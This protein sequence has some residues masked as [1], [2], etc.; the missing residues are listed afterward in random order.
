MYGVDESYCMDIGVCPPNKI[1][2][3]DNFSPT[4]SLTF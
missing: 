3:Q 4:P 1:L 2:V